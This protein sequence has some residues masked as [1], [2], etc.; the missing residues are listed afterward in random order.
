M[1]IRIVGDR[2]LVS[3][4][5]QCFAVAAASAFLL[6]IGYRAMGPNGYML[7]QQREQEKK[8]LERDVQQLTLQHLNLVNEVDQL[9][10][11][12]R[13]IEKVARQEL[14]LAKP[15]E[16]IYVLPPPPNPSR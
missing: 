9:K 13:A 12:P 14:K 4:I 3:T 5:R 7:L 2:P 11:D 10:N 1:R 6:M 15:G 16:Y 8:K